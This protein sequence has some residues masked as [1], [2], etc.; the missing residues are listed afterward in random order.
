MNKELYTRSRKEDANPCY[1][2]KYI[3]LNVAVILWYVLET[4]GSA[5]WKDCV[6]EDLHGL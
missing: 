3:A 5:I 2:F 1:I 6:R 4:A